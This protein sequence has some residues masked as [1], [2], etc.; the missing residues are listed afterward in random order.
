MGD[1]DTTYPT[2][3]HA[4]QAAKSL[5]IKE[6]IHIS[7][8]NSP[9]AAKKAGRKLKLRADWEEIKLAVTIPL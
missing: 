5:D 9:G 7:K 4:F 2:V 8:L 1:I 3:E 6:R